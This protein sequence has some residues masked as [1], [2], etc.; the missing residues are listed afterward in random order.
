V[1]YLI[2]YIHELA[3]RAR[4]LDSVVHLVRALHRNRWAAGSILW[5]HFLQLLLYKIH[6]FPCSSTAYKS[7]GAITLC[8]LS[9]NF[10]ATQ[11]ARE[12]ARCI[13][14]LTINKSRNIFVAT[15]I[16]RSIHV[17]SGSTFCNDCGN[18]FLKHCAV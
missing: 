14:C 9:R 18:A 3:V 17:E 10:V 4:Q 2:V 13:N 16:A 6:K 5:L 8:N 12:I 15:T 7:K 1:H 11:V